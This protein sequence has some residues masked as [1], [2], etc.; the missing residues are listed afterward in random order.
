MPLLNFKCKDCGFLFDELVR[1]SEHTEGV[2]CPKCAGKNLTRV[3]EGKCY[4]A[5][6]SGSGECSGHCA[7]CPGC[8]H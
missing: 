3:Y 2:E 5:I 1:S 6:G 7:S 8:K 4:G